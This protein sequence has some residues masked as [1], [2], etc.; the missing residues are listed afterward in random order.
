MYTAFCNRVCSLILNDSLVGYMDEPDSDTWH[1]RQVIYQYV[2][3]K[4]K[5]QLS[6][7]C[8]FNVSN[9]FKFAFE[10]GNLA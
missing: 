7:I 2:S 5:F 4:R 9:L 6:I 10:L 1:T 3:S 8:L